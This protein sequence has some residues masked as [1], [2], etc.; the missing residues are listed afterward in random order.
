MTT[1]VRLRVQMGTMHRTRYLDLHKTLSRDWVL[2][3]V[4]AGSRSEV[5]VAPSLRSPAFVC[6]LL[7]THHYDLG[8]RQSLR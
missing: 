1:A 4:V 3:V 6:T 5:L 2:V 7:H 8:S